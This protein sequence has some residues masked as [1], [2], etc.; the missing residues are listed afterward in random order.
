VSYQHVK[1]TLDCLG[2]ATLLATLSPLLSGIGLA[3]WVSSG[4]PI[5]F[6]Q[7]R[8]GWRGKVFQILKFRT[9]S[10]TTDAAGE[11]LPDTQRMTR[12]GRVLRSL[13]L[14]ELP[15]L[16]NILKGDMSFV[17][18]RP[19]LADYLP[20]Y[21]QE[22]LRRHD[23]RPGLTGWAQINGRNALSWEDRFKL[24]LWYVDHVSPALDLKILLLTVIK[25]L[26]SEGINQDENTTAERF[27]GS[28]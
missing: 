15:E 21:S 22:Q 7:A 23:V 25:V 4:R 5:F 19:F 3:I 17:G 11:L 18:P 1:R 10:S 24:D 6:R 28:R 8:G 2:A 26:E 27:Q 12:V 13:S 16:L 9:M 14:D 20:L